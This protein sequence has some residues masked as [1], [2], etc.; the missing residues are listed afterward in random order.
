MPWGK[1]NGYTPEERAQISKYALENGNT[2]AVRHFFKGP[3]SK[4]NE[5]NR[6]KAEGRVVQVYAWLHH[7]L[8]RFVHALTIG[9]SSNLKFA[10]SFWRPIRQI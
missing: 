8:L 9:R 2:R 10:N 7:A 1:Y 3:W 6:E 4:N 5:I